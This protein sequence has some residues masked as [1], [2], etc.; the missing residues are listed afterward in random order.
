[1]G[2]G[3]LPG[4]GSARDSAASKGDPGESAAAGHE[5]CWQLLVVASLALR[6]GWTSWEET[7]AGSNFWTEK[8]FEAWDGVESI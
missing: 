7:S 2:D 6:L 1:M 4:C 8:L 3:G 5:I